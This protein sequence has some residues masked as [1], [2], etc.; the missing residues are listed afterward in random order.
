MFL[1]IGVQKKRQR[2]W[3]YLKHLDDYGKGVY[4]LRK[5][6]QAKVTSVSASLGA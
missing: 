1:S 6:F 2:W 5:A 3:T 4:S